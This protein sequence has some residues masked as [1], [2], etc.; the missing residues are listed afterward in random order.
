M[1]GR[2]WARRNRAIKGRGYGSD[3]STEIRCCEEGGGDAAEEEGRA[4]RWPV[5]AAAGRMV[6][7]GKTAASAAGKAGKAAGK[8]AAKRASAAE[9][10]GSRSG[11]ARRSTARK[12][13]EK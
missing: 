12:R 3:K 11:T 8:A 2:L 5:Q 13:T 4:G 10:T 6:K 7:E 1:A 9:T